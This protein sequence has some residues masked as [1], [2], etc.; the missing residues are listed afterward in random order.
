MPFWSK[1]T[2]PPTSMICG[3]KK[4][5][6][7]KLKMLEIFVYNY[8]FISNKILPR[9]KMNAKVVIWFLS[10][11]LNRSYAYVLPKWSDIFSSL[12]PYKDEETLMLEEMED[13]GEPR[14]GFVQV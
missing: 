1:N 8:L 5:H 7:L 13:N 3:F 11:A 12:E 14:I 6:M 4:E 9:R 2:D 10:L